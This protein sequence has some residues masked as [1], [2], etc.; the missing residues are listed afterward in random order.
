MLEKVE[1]GTE[2]LIIDTR[3]QKLL[4]KLIVKNHFPPL[5]SYIAGATLAFFGYRNKKKILLSKD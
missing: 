2:N 5:L 4:S 1:S 3:N